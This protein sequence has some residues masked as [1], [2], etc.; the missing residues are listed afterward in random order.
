VDFRDTACIGPR[1]PG[2]QARRIAR[3]YQRA[4]VGDE[5]LDLADDRLRI[6]ERRAVG[7]L[8]GGE[9]LRR[10]EQEPAGLAW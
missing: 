8:V 10:P 7:S 6:E 4:E 1:E 2:D 3:A 5:L 9:G